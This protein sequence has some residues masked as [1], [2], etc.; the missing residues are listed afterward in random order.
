MSWKDNLDCT[1]LRI[2]MTDASPLRVLAGPGTG[3]TYT[4]IRRV[5]RLLED[6]V[7]PKRILVSTFT[8]TA[9][10]DLKH[11]LKNLHVKG[12]TLVNATTVH[13]LCFSILNRNE[14][15]EITDRVP[16]PLL[17][18]E[19]R[20]LLEDLKQEGF[21]N[22]YRR[23]ERLR[24]FEAA[25]A[26]L[27]S[28][29]PGWPHDP[30]DQQFDKLLRDWLV[31]HA[32]M[33][34]GELVPEALR[35]LRKNPLSPD[36]S[37]FSH[38]LVDEYQDLNASEQEFIN[39]LAPEEGLT[40]I[41]DEDQSIYSFKYAHPKGIA[42]FSRGRPKTT[43]QNLDLC[44]RCPPNI[45]EMA[46]QLISYNADRSR[47][48]LTPN[49]ENEKGEVLVYQWESMTQEADGLATLVTNLVQEG[50]V[51]PGR[52]LVLAPRRQFGYAIRD[53]LN[54]RNV[55]AL[56]FFQ[57][58]AL[59]G[60]PRDLEKSRVQQAF[61][62]LTLTA[63]PKDKVA[64]RC[65]CGF[66]SPNLRQKAWIRIRTLCAEKDLTLQE[67][68]HLIQSGEIK[69]DSGREIKTRLIELETRLRELVPLRGSELFDELFPENDSDFN[70]IRAIATS[71]PPNADAKQ[72]LEHLRTNITQPELPTDVDF[73]R[74]M[75]LHK[76]KGLTADLVIVMGCIE[77]IIP[78][79]PK[80]ASETERQKVRE[81]QRRLFYVAVTR[82][83]RMLVLSSVTGL[84]RD[85]AHKMNIPVRP[86]GH[87]SGTITTAF[88]DELGPKCPNPMSGVDAVY[89]DATF[90]KQQ[91]PPRTHPSD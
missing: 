91:T 13:A 24:A 33:L 78:S 29:Q 87:C 57:E 50:K 76:S 75:S 65:W 36:H 88:I 46:N 25:W 49:S 12:A 42:D 21:G 39:I 80:N 58:Q 52:V 9:A 79:L 38:V 7:P 35:Y 89:G 61:T 77:G 37:A 4:L 59:D 30:I 45:V 51:K 16:R 23:R 31:F 1:S 74:V 11:E 8:R 86:K 68:L 44:R 71:M 63:N 82:A 60:D 56:S 43:D 83:R 3:K 34:I 10:D 70:Q 32:A 90:A 84:P 41:G 15:L 55:N 48:K 67:T 27:Q 18:F 40:I 26:R 73:V 17:D 53:A 28:E 22:I 81:E 20:F 66:G 19:R 72:L 54:A 6:G 14:V 47:R 69:L 62:L 85:V 2:A 64:L 5:A